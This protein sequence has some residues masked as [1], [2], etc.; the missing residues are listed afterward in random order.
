MLC[1]GVQPSSA[2]I[3]PETAGDFRVQ[4]RC[5]IPEEAPWFKDGDV[6]CA[7]C[8]LIQ[9]DR[10]DAERPLPIQSC[11]LSHLTAYLLPW[12]REARSS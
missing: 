3:D 6:F 11:V 7:L 5:R 8:R 10:K 12:G 1:T 9:S 2:V 4:D